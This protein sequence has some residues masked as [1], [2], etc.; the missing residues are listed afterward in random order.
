MGVIKIR[1]FLHLLFILIYV[2]TYGQEAVEPIRIGLIADIQYADKEDGKTRFYRSSLPKLEQA[3]Q[4]LNQ[5]SLLFTVVLGDLVDEGPKDLAPIMQ[6]LRLLKAPFYSILGNHD[7]ATEYIPHLHRKFDMPKEY[8]V[9]DK[10]DWKF[11][12]L[13]TNELSSYAVKTG[14]SLEKECIALAKRQE[15]QGRANVQPWNGG[16]GTKQMKWLKKELTSAEKQNKKVMI[17]THHP[18][19]PENGLEA[20]N[21]RE[22]LRVFEAFKS[23]KAV[24]SG[25]HHAGNFVMYQDIPFITLEGM[26]ETK[27]QTAFGYM[28]ILPDRLQIYGKGRMSSQ[29]VNLR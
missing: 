5:D 17:F 13:N 18:I 4:Q 6:Q 16:I 26:I 14:S 19:L 20:L 7:F 8:Y 1:P 25:H 12:F 27:D 9:V 21:S 24:L 3:V 28:D 29:K 2:N 10:G 23:V 22:L 11:V 15:E